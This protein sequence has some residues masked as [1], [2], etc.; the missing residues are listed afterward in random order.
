VSDG[1]NRRAILTRFGTKSASK[2]DHRGADDD[3]IGRHARLVVMLDK[4]PHRLGFG[5]VGNGIGSGLA[6]LLNLA[7]VIP[8]WVTASHGPSIE[9]CRHHGNGMLDA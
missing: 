6:M 7:G 1:V 2:I 4:R 8:A 9:P 3:F 5:F